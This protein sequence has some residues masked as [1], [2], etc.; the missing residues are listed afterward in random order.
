MS[1]GLAILC[2][3]QTQIYEWVATRNLLVISCQR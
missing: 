1:V 3:T 2:F